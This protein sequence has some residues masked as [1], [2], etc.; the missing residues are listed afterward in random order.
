MTN[1]EIEEYRREL[2]KARQLKDNGQRNIAL[3]ALLNA[4]GASGCGG[5]KPWP[6]RDAQNIAS[7][8]EALQTAAMINMAKEASQKQSVKKQS[9]RMNVFISHVNEELSLALMA[10]AYH[11]EVHGWT[12]L[13][14]PWKTL[15]HCWYC[16]VQFRLDVPG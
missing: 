6:E 9:D 8:Q 11:Q 12:D 13:I 3:I 7:I 2:V 5:D 14:R 16:A 10:R 1:E 15:M 4:L